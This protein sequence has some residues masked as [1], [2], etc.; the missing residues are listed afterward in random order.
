MNFPDSSAVHA[1]SYQLTVAGDE[2]LLGASHR[3]AD[4]K[5]LPG[6]TSVDGPVHA[7]VVEDVDGL[8]RQVLGIEHHLA[9]GDV[10]QIRA[11]PRAVERRPALA[12]IGGQEKV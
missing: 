4:A 5:A 7:D 10:R 9:R 6:F 8:V 1:Y 2:H 11:A 12:I 3:Q